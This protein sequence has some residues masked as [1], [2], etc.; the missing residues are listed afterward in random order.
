MN[1]PFRLFIQVTKF[2]PRRE[3]TC[4]RRFANNTCADQPAHPRSLISAFVIRFLESIIRILVKGEISI[5]YLFSEA[6]ERGFNLAFSETPKTGFLA[7]R[8]KCSWYTT[9]SI[10][11]QFEIS[12]NCDAKSLHCKQIVN[13]NT[14]RGGS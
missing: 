4:F 5:F 8:P 10:S 1:L 14:I 9:C 11:L 3:K 7:A 2:G 13:V 12:L 6:E